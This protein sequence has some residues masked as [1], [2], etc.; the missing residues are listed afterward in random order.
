MHEGKKQEQD[1]QSE[2]EELKKLLIAQQE[3]H[4][5]ELGKR[6]EIIKKFEKLFAEVEGKQAATVA[7]FEDKIKNLTNKSS[8]QIKKLKESLAEYQDEKKD[9]ENQIN[10]LTEQIDA[11]EE[12][13]ERLNMT[14]EI[15]GEEI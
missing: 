4:Q 9:L 7:G 5:G 8:N 1:Y 6:D 11:I 14:Q 3:E 2:I 10:K 12:E 13:K 15:Q